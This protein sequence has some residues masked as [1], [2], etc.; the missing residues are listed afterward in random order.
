VADGTPIGQLGGQQA[1]C[2]V[3]ALVKGVLTGKTPV[4]DWAV[5]AGGAALTNWMV[6]AGGMQ[7]EIGMVSTSKAAVSS[8]PAQHGP[9]QSPSVLREERLDEQDQ[10]LSSRSWVFTASS[11]TA[12]I[13]I[14]T[15]KYRGCP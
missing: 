11:M 14:F 4:E 9:P 1:R 13:D 2:L 5:K 15:S 10:A 3:V 6:V 7:V 8:S 12:A